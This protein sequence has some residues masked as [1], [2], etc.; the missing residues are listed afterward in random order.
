MHETK[1]MK[2][3]FSLL[4]FTS[5]VCS[6]SKCVAYTDKTPR[7]LQNPPAF[8]ITASDEQKFVWFR[9]A[10]VGTRSILEMLDTHTN[11]SQSGYNLPFVAKKY[12]TY[13]KFAFVRNP[14]DR[15]V[16]C[17]H[18]QVLPKNIPFYKE[19]W[20][21]DFDFFVNFINKQDMERCDVHMR[22]QTTLFPLNDVDFIGRFENFAT[23]LRHVFVK[24]GLP[25]VEIVHR[26]GSEHAH[27]S[28]Y[29]NKT[30]KA[31]IAKKYRKDIETFN[32]HFEKP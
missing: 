30:T 27:Y 24:I 10:K 6:G 29:Y 23:D 28:T 26:N 9:V 13:F 7:H 31:I 14:W 3:L 32:Y 21:K 1:Q 25:D 5:I 16:S 8:N 19:C 18:R 2:M 22:L 15:V 11:L 20:D 4:L 17:Y 12:K